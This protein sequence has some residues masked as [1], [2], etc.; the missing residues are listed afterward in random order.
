MERKCAICNGIIQI[1]KNNT[2][3]A[4]Q[5]KNKFYHYDCFHKLCD[6]KIATSRT[7]TQWQEVKQQIDELVVQ[8]TKEQADN[9][10]RDEL[11]RW[12]MAQYNL[13]CMSKRLYEK[14]ASVS[15]GTYKGLAYAISWEELLDEWKYYLDEIFAVLR[16]KELVY[17]AAVNYSIAIL[18]SKN[19]EYREVLKRKKV[20]EAARV[21]EIRNNEIDSVALEMMQRSYERIA[22]GNRR[23]ELFKEVMGDGD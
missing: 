2:N 17:E 18:L 22:R 9:V 23:A 13:S 3:K 7:S 5:Y 4:I 10:A 1:D 8:T 21:V 11:N 6:Q 15:N 19:A 14:L 16:G 20:E 12:I